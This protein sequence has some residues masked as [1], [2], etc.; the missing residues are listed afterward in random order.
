MENKPKK[1]V[2]IREEHYSLGFG[3]KER[4][5]KMYILCEK[6]GKKL[7]MGDIH[8]CTKCGRRC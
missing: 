4:V 2:L 3:K 8:M 5:L 7:D 6:C 1:V